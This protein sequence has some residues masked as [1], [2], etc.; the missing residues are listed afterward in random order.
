MYEHADK[1]T[2]APM[3]ETDINTSALIDKHTN[4]QMKERTDKRQ[5]V[6]MATAAVMNIQ[7]K[8]KIQ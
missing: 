1:N 3:N 8:G 5:T 4:I 6:A 7:R 2:K